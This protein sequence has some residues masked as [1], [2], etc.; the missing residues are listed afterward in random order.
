[1]K[2]GMAMDLTTGW[3]F[4]IER[5]REAARQYLKKAKPAL[6]IGSPMCK[7]FS[8]LQNL[9]KK[10]WNEERQSEYVEAIEHIRFVVSLYKEQVN[11]GR[12]FL[13][14]HPAG[15]SSWDLEEIKKMQLEINVTVN[16]A[17]QCMY[18]LKTQ[19]KTKK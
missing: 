5:H 13:H 4:T 3:D 8:S 2:T 6:L 19:G 1:M 14:E 18:G 16:T 10:T 11:E 7:M 12:L 17:D 15:A 9:S